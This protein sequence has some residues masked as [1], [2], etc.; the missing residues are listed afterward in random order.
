MPRERDDH[1]FSQTNITPSWTRRRPERS[2]VGWRYYSM[3]GCLRTRELP[4]FRFPDVGT[5]QE[6][7][8]QDGIARY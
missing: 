8:A 4:P 3:G 7:G 5:E 1:V 2:R 6:T